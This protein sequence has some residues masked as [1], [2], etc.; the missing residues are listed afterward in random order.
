MSEVR[1]HRG[2]SYVV[3]ITPPGST[4]PFIL[5]ARR[6]RARVRGKVSS[7]VLAGRLGS[8]NAYDDEHIEETALRIGMAILED[9]QIIQEW[10]AS[11]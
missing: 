8:Q 4:F 10:R 9:S 2:D 1:E 3:D 6:S 5:I 7:E 11:R